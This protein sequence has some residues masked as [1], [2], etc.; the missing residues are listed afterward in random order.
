MEK[1]RFVR[2]AIT[3]ILIGIIFYI[4]NMIQ[5]QSDVGSLLLRTLLFICIFLYSIYS[6]FLAS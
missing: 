6:T 5:N 2:G 1:S 3:A 4:V